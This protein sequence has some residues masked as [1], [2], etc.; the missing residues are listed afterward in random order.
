MDFFFVMGSND[1][2]GVTELK[3][4]HFELIERAYPAYSLVAG[5][6]WDIARPQVVRQ[7]VDRLWAFGRSRG[8]PNAIYYDSRIG[9]GGD[10]HHLQGANI[11]LGSFFGPNPDKLVNCFDL[12]AILFVML[13]SFG[14]RADGTSIIQ[15]AAC[16]WDNPWGFVNEG[17]L[18]GQAGTP[19]H[20]RNNPFWARLD[21]TQN[22]APRI[23]TNHPDRT[24][25]S[26]HC[27][28]TFEMQPSQTRVVNACHALCDPADPDPNFPHF[29]LSSG[30]QTV[31]TF[32]ATNIDQTRPYGAPG[33]PVDQQRTFCC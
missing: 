13:K 12:A 6:A 24:A 1:V 8:G 32:R 16:V 28:V 25:F 9:V 5:V 11:N 27:Y 29:N 20:R 30:N 23:A 15:N 14:R 18:F 3:K 4:F 33:V 17:P 31:A 2:P 19:A 22:T 26:C 21:W 10:R 7:V